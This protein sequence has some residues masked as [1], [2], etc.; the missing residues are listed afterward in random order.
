MAALTDEQRMV[1]QQMFTMNSFSTVWQTIDNVYSN[2]G[3]GDSLTDE[4]RIAEYTYINQQLRKY[5]G[6][7]EEQVL[8]HGSDLEGM[9][10]EIEKLI[11]TSSEYADDRRQL[12]YNFTR[13]IWLLDAYNGIIWLIQGMPT[14]DQGEDE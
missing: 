2:H 3:M 6:K 4:E 13:D 12:M 14:Q 5:I 8:S 10:S 11:S 1:L 7:A 9:K